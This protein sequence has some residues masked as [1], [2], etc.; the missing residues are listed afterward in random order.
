[1]TRKTLLQLDVACNSSVADHSDVLFVSRH[2]AEA[3]QKEDPG[4]PEA[5]DLEEEAVLTYIA[6]AEYWRSIGRFRSVAWPHDSFQLRTQR[7]FHVASCLLQLMCHLAVLWREQP[8]C[9]CSMGGLKALC[10]C[11]S[12]ALQTLPLAVSTTNLEKP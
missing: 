11:V 8:S 9:C 1:M 10:E 5:S 12:L 2:R 6:A 7:R 3:L 4:S